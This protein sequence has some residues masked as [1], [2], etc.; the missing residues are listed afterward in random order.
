MPAEVCNAPAAIVL[1]AAPALLLV[2]FTTTVQPPAGIDV[3]LAMVKLPAPAEALTPVQVPVLPP[4][5]IVI[6]VGKASV[7]RLESVI[8]STLLLPIVT[9]R[10]VL[11]PLAMSD[12]EKDLATVGASAE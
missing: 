2:T 12:G 10:F 8:A 7:N 3:P 9:V 1:T 4:V 6:P 5:L 11:P